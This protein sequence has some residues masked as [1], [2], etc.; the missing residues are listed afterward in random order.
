MSARVS[1]DSWGWWC[2]ECGDGSPIS[3]DSESEATAYAQAHDERQ[4]R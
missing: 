4:H 3:Y 2:A 1:P